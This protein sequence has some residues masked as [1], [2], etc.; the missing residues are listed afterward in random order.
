MTRRP[1]LWFLVPGAM[2]TPTGGY[3]YDR[4]IIAGLH[5]LGWL[6]EVGRLD[7]SFPDPSTSALTAAARTLAALP[8]ASA[9]VVDGLAFG[10]LPAAAAAHGGRLRLI[11]LI[12]HPLAAESGLAPERVA[13]LHQSETRALA[14]A[15]GVVVTS[16]ATADLLGD[17]QVP[18]S[19]I[20]VVEPGTDPAPAARGSAGG[21][22]QLLCVAALTQRKGH[23]LLLQALAPLRGRDWRLTCVGSPAR[24]PAYAARLTALCDTLD[25]AGRVAFVGVLDE[26]A[27]ARC[28]DG[29]DLFVLATRFEGYGMACAE[30][31][32]HGL[33]ILATRAGAV[34]ATVPS[35][36][37]LLVAPDDPAALTA[38]LARLL[39]E[40][41]L[42]HRLAAGSRA[43][44]L[45]L[46]TW[47]TAAAAFARSI[48][49]LCDV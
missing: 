31:L 35:T 22:L 36:A 23:D 44:G 4:R 28:Y 7:A 24:D 19:R 20:R 33:P 11:A 45:G 3:R 12:H 9:V 37:G 8:D 26:A 1:P 21:P 25:L 14:A 10:A 18:R 2:D 43:A 39:E 15:R 46:P 29:A 40:P 47:Q 49:E 16:A 34:P 5:D 41:K 32:A 48:E 38:A 13:A 17:Y 42:R 6:V 30:A 27:L